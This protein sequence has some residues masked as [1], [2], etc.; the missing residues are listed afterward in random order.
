MGNFADLCRAYAAIPAL[1]MPAHPRDPLLVSDD[2][3]I[4]TERLRQAV[5]DALQCMPDGYRCPF[6]VT[7]LEQRAHLAKAMQTEFRRRAGR[8]E[9]AIFL[10]NRMATWLD[11]LQ[12]AVI[13]WCDSDRKPRLER[14]AA[15]TSNF[16]NLF[17]G[18]VRRKLYGLRQEPKP[19]LVA[20]SPYQHWGP[21]TVNG[22]KVLEYVGVQIGIVNLPRSYADY[23]IL[24]SMLAHEVYGHDAMHS[25]R[26]VH[27]SRG[28]VGQDTSRS[29][30][31]DERD[32]ELVTEMRRAVCGAVN[33]SG[34][35]TIWTDAWMEEAAADAMGVLA[36]GPAFML[37]MLAW[38]NATDAHDDSALFAGFGALES[39]LP[40]RNGRPAGEHPPDLLRFHV[41]RGALDEL[42]KRCGHD[43]E[44]QAVASEIERHQTRTRTID[45]FDLNEGG[46]VLSYDA[47][48]LAEHAHAVGAWLVSTKFKTLQDKALLDFNPWCEANEKI[49]QEFARATGVFGTAGTAAYDRAYCSPRHCLA[50]ATMAVYQ[51]PGQIGAVNAILALA[52]S[53]QFGK[54]F[55]FHGTQE[56]A[57]ETRREM[58]NLPPTAMP[59]QAAPSPEGTPD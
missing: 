30:D 39:R 26:D 54:T 5:A 17:K 47:Q 38:M 7:L 49:A 21:H 9:D 52:L 4:D 12:R 25:L 3:H 57:P 35:E 27:H 42:G 14:M 59:A 28:K 19:P 55:D 20:L 46:V 29:A 34:W 43:A 48:T 15:V 22:D 53:D 1:R 37:G 8:G 6:G 31:K 13:D 33:G 51:D 44:W 11:V 58:A 10:S 40:L 23:P 56:P 16:Y 18:E 41:M 24:W 45:V 32:V 2:G 36:M 50:G